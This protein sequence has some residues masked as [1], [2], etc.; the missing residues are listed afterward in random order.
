MM[1]LAVFLAVMVISMFLTSRT[2]VVGINWIAVFIVHS[3]I[4][5]WSSVTGSLGYFL[6]YRLFL[7]AIPEGSYGGDQP[8]QRLDESG[9]P[10]QPPST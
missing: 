6:S 7:P 5:V 2:S 3:V 1:T 10:Y 4:L 8:V 9:N